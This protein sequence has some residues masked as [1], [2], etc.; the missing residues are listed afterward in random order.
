M[1]K[2]LIELAGGWLELPRVFKSVIL[3]ATTGYTIGN[4]T[5]LQSTESQLAGKVHCASTALQQAVDHSHY[6]QQ[7]GS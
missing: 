7:E 3:K 1:Q 5:A 6:R 4:A 2:T